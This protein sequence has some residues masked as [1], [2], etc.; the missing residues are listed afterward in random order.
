M[1]EYLYP[2]SFYAGL[3]LASAG[4]DVDFKAFRDGK[5]LSFDQANRDFGNFDLRLG[6][7][8]SNQNR[9]YMI[10][11]FWGLGIYDISPE[12]HHNHEGLRKDL[13]AYFSGGAK[14]KY[15]IRSFFDFGYNLKVLY[16]FREK[17]RFKVPDENVCQ[18]N[19]LWGGE[20]GIPFTWHLSKTKRWDIELEPYFLTLGF[21]KEQ[22]TFGTKL[23]FGFNF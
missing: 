17:V 7:T 23:L 14:F 13:F 8:V 19:R 10:S 1:Y 3:D 22:M 16:V 4:S 20:I 12:D 9:S 15:K 2:N 5:R 18:I 21:S 6:Y 11:L